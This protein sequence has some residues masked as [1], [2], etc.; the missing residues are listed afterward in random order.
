MVI[1]LTF[2]PAWLKVEMTLERTLPAASRNL[3]NFELLK[4]SECE[5]SCTAVATCAQNNDSRDRESWQTG[6]EAGPAAGLFASCM[7]GSHSLKCGKYCRG[8]RGGAQQN[9][10]SGL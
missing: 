2:L 3:A 10:G 9:A 6:P 1:L 4:P 7:P 5:I 8:G